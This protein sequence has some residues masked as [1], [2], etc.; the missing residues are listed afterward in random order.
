VAIPLIQRIVAVIISAGL[1]LLIVQLIRRG[2]CEETRDL[3]GGRADDLRALGI[4]GLVNW[5]A[6][7]CAPATRRR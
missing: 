5:L 2:G 4:R 3:A 7:C 1:L 6:G